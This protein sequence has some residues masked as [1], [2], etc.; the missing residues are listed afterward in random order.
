VAA[1]LLFGA[2]GAI[3]GGYLLVPVLSRVVA[4]LVR[5]PLRPLLSARRPAPALIDARDV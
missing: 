3:A 1:G 5:T 4:R 2:V